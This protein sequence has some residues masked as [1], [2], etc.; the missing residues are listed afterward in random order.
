MNQDNNQS[1]GNI[2]FEIKT[3]NRTDFSLE[4]NLTTNN[5]E[6]VNMIDFEII[7]S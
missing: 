2:E 1:L 7:E 3:W 6:K 4:F 5:Y